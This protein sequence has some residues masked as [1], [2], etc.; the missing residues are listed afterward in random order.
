MA[1]TCRR[2]IRSTAA[3]PALTLV[4]VVFTQVGNLIG[5]RYETR[6]GLD[7]GLFRNHLFV[8]GVAIELGFAVAVV[9]LPAL[10]RALGT[11][12]IPPWILGLA[13][14]G[15]PVLFLADWLRKRGARNPAE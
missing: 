2:T 15:A 13:A 11:G 5:R 3:R 1:T 6:S 9:Y 14:L 7:W 8:V 12:P 4:S 10:G